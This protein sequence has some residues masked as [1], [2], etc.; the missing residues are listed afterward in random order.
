MQSCS[1]REL[2]MSAASDRLTQ[3]GRHGSNSAGQVSSVLCIC[4]EG[5]VFRIG[6][7][8]T[9]CKTLSRRYMRKPNR[10]P[11]FKVL[12]ASTIPQRRIF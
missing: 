5:E 6:C 12:M 7:M 3:T 11:K 10:F 1:Q 4:P 2:H 8:H 9:I